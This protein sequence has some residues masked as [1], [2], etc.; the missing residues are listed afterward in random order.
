MLFISSYSITFFRPVV[1]RRMEGR[2]DEGKDGWR[3]R[4]ME[5][6]IDRGKDGWRE[7]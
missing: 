7:R 4:W 6:K 3:E 1:D 5:R 2:M